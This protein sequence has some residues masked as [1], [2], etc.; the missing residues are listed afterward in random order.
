[1]VALIIM[2]TSINRDNNKLRTFENR[3]QLAYQIFRSGSDFLISS[4]LSTLNEGYLIAIR[5]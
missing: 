3:Q 4:I 5:Y 1:M 2:I